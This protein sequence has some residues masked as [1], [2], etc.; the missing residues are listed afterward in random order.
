MIL[1]L[2]P[3]KN[4]E[5]TASWKNDAGLYADQITIVARK[6]DKGDKKK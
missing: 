3:L 2:Y 1:K 5:I 6:N 4:C